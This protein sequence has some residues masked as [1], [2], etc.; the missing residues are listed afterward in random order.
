MTY[1]AIIFSVVFIN[2]I[3]LTNLM[4][5]PIFGKETK[6]KDLVIEG[7]KTLVV[8]LV[9]TLIVYPIN[10]YLLV[11]EEIAYF[12]LLF[13]VIFAA[14]LTNLVDR[15]M[16]KIGLSDKPVKNF[17][18]ITTSNVVIIVVG[19]LVTQNASYLGSLAQTIGLVLGHLL[20][21]VLLFVTVPKIDLPGVPKAFKGIP[22]LLITIGLIAMVFMGL[23]GIL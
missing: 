19:L 6:L 23:N 20:V 7:L 16:N 10:R 21:T 4:G 15:L 14:L 1:L 17:S 22:L 2:N 8:A 18:L 13:V 12:A 9:T 11:P 5:L 3:L